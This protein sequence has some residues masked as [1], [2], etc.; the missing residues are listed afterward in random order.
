MNADHRFKLSRLRWNKF[1]TIFPA[2]VR[3][4][5]AR[6]PQRPRSLNVEISV[7]IKL[8]YL[9]GFSSYQREVIRVITELRGNSWTYKEVS[10]FLN[11][12]GFRTPR[13]KKFRPNH[14]ERMLKKYRHKIQQ[15]DFIK[16]FL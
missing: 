12:K 14:V 7:E 15:E 8:C 6:N 5:L 10:D 13:G 1:Q 4:E 2:L 3:H 11:S 16:I 9:N